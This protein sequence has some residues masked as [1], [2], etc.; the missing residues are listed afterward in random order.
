MSKLT[1]NSKAAAS[2]VKDQLKESAGRV[3]EE[4]KQEIK[5]PPRGGTG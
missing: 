1:R 4:A 2:T 3:A 5:K